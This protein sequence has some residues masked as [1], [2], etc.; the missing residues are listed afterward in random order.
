MAELGYVSCGYWR[1]TSLPRMHDAS[2]R[3]WSDRVQTA[4][5]KSK[6]AEVVY[7]RLCVIL[8]VRVPS[9]RSHCVASLT[10][11][12]LRRPVLS[13]VDSPAASA[14]DTAA[15]AVRAWYGSAGMQVATVALL[16]APESAP[17]A[18]ADA[19]GSPA[20]DQLSEAP[21]L[22]PE[23]PLLTAHG[24][25]FGTGGRVDELEARWSAMLCARELP[26]EPASRDPSFEPDVHVTQEE[27]AALPL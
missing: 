13:P 3:H 9:V 16:E 19:Q 2:V 27:A 24:C 14:C 25:G 7:T 8:V 4:T 10:P 11:D 20:P 12:A 18:A 26:L 15:E 17:T 22:P 5:F 21:P 23:P 1:R 6:R